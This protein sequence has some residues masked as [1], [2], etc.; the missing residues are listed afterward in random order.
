[1]KKLAVMMT[2]AMAVTAALAAGAKKKGAQA[3]AGSDEGPVAQGKEAKINIDQMPKTG[4]QSC[5]PF[6]GIQGRRWSVSAT[7]NRASG[8]S[9]RPSTRPTRSSSTS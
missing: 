9:L 7:R 1:M 2:V 8:S 5:L 4:S 3:M 6:M